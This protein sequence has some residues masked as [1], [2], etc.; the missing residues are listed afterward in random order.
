MKTVF[1]FIPDRCLPETALDDLIQLCFTFYSVDTGT[2]GYVIVYGLGEGIWL[3]ENHA[4]TFSQ[5]DD[6][7]VFIDVNAVQFYAS[8][9]LNAFYKV[10][11]AVQ[12]LKECGFSAS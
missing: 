11:H 3:L 4:D 10:I 9:D 8:F 7:K 12:C 6:I 1:K 2:V 5:F